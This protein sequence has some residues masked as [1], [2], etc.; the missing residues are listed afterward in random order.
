MSEVWEE[1]DESGLPRCWRIVWRGNQAKFTQ[2]PELLQLLL[3]T[4]GTTL[5]EASPTDCIWGIGLAEDDPAAH[6]RDA[7]RGQNWLGEVLTALRDSLDA[8]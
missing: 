4:R 8:C 3:D 7:W 1:E 2:N 6:H 5:A